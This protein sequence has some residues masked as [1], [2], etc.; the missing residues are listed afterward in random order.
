MTTIFLYCAAVGGSLLVLQFLLLLLGVGG[1][2]ADHGGMHFDTGVDGGHDLGHDVGHDQSSFLKLLSLQTL[3]GFATFFGLVGMS[4]RTAGWSPTATLAAAVLAG[5]GAVVAVGKAMQWISRLQCSGTLDFANAIGHDG[6]V[7][8]H[9]PAAGSGHGRVL[10]E[11]QG[12]NVECR[13]TT[14]GAEVP[15][16]AIVRVVA[17][18][19]EVLE[20]EPIDRAR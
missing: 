13:A 12:R 10:I 16:G 5:I 15:N 11:I 1:D 20:V 18:R 2:G 14:R 9:I 4:G 17:V 6:R 7:Y 3:T 19:D 8:L